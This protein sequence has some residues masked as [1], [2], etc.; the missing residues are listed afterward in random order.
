MVAS[1]GVSTDKGK[2]RAPRGSTGTLAYLRR[3]RTYLWIGLVNPGPPSSL[4]RR[5]AR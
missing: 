1:K 3:I 4:P 5:T 2:G